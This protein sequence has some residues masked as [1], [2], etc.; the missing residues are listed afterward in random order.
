MSEKLSG[1]PNHISIGDATSTESAI[2]ASANA[3]VAWDWRRLYLEVQ[4]L[5]VWRL[6]HCCSLGQLREICV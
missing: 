4:D 5:L 3:I 6:L 1:D 2:G